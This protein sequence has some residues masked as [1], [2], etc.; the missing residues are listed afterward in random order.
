MA[1]TGRSK[2]CTKKVPPNHFGAI[3][4]P[5]GDLIRGSDSEEESDSKVE[6]PDKCTGSY[7]KPTRKELCRWD[8]VI[9]SNDQFRDLIEESKRM[10]ETIEKRLPI[11]KH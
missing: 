2:S 8:G 4:E 11:S 5:N 3:L 9:V 10:R 6:D 1:T 7:A